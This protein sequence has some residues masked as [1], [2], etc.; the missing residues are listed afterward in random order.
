MEEVVLRLKELLFPSIAD[1]AVLSVDVNIEIVRV[2]AQCI[3]DGAV[4]PVCGV[5]S[6]RVHGSYLRFLADVP[7][8]G[9]SVVLRLR[10]RRFTCGNSGCARRTFVEQV[11]GLTRRHGQRTERL[12]STLAAVGLAL[13]GRAGARIARVLGVSV[14]RST[15]LR[16]VDALPEPEIPAPRV[17]GVDE[18]ATRRGRHY[19]TVLVDIETRRPVDLLPDREASSLAA[20]LADRPGVEVVCR[21]RAPFFAEGASA[22]APQTVQVA[23]RWHLWHNLS[24]AA[25][26]AVAQHRRCLRA[27]LPAAPEPEPEP[28]PGEEPS[29]SP[30]PTGHRFADRTRARHASVHALLEAGHSMRSVQRQLG[31]AWHTV[32]RFADAAK[33]EDLFTGQWQNRP[34]VLDDYKPYLDDR[35]DEGITNAWKLWEEIVP[36]GYK[37]SY[38]RVRAYL[39]KKRTSPRPVTA[40]PPSPRTVSKWILSRPETLTEPE[41]LQLKTIRTQCPELDALTRHVRSFATMLTDRQGERLPDWLAAVRQDDLPSLH[42]LAAGI[43]RDLDAVTAGLTLPWSSGAVEGHVNRIKMLKRQMFGRAGFQ[44]LRKRVLMS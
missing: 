44:L 43:D 22:G 7:S 31:M 16:L 17:V 35:W 8:G 26:R 15:V 29:G 37:G 4:C 9:R 33:P 3:A 18:Y 13:A 28:A 36:L 5:W 38:Q 11:P 34:S 40:R 42:T 20:W 10:V 19:G 41:Q 12:R 1:V 39:H 25:E 2:D 6:N 21:D 14:S 27:L 24:E 30:W 23:D 32:K